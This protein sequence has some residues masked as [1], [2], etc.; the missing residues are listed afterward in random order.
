MKDESEGDVVMRKM[1]LM[2]V[3]NHKV[4]T[5]S[6]ANNF[7][8]VSLVLMMAT[9]QVKAD[10]Q[11]K[12]TRH[13]SKEMKKLISKHSM[14]VRE[15]MCLLG[16]GCVNPFNIPGSA[17]H[18]NRTPDEGSAREPAQ[19][20]SATKSSAHSHSAIHPPISHTHFP[21]AE[22]SVIKEM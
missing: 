2:T 7:E 19:N 5:D 12:G 8:T 4:C 15:M 13:K 16:I 17:T 1:K 22:I 18:L 21:V 9:R 14:C 11:V 3:S 6:E 10:R 20:V